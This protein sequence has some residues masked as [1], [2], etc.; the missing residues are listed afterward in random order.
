MKEAGNAWQGY[1]GSL[2]AE[3]KPWIYPLYSLTPGP[4]HEQAQIPIH[5]YS[6]RCLPCA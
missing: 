3:S 1:F 5:Y 6:V 4:N 2:S